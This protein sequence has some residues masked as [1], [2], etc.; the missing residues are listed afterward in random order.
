VR[1]LFSENSWTIGEDDLADEH[2][3]HHDDAAP[4]FEPT[5]DS[6]PPL[7][8]KQRRSLPDFVAEHDPLFDNDDDADFDHEPLFAPPKSGSG[9]ARHSATM[10]NSSAP[11]NINAARWS[12]S[13]NSP[14]NHTS[15]LT[16]ALQQAGNGAATLTQPGSVDFGN[17]LGTG[18]QDSS[19][20]DAMMTGTSYMGSG[21]QPISV[22]NRTRRE[23]NTGSFINGMSWGPGSLP[24]GSWVN[25]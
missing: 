9:S 5:P 15:T 16:S 25:E 24:S 6:Q 3:H 21:A 18:L 1:T 11:I 4:L 22:Q 2:H 10:N 20:G 7:L 12:N 23:S 8:S 19:R 14:R 17:G 13:T